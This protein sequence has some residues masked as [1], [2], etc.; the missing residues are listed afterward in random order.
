MNAMVSQVLMTSQSARERAKADKEKSNAIHQRVENH[1]SEQ[2]K[3]KRATQVLDVIIK[4]LK[5]EHVRL[6]NA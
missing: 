5:S 3:I 4:Q 6:I 1:T 2:R